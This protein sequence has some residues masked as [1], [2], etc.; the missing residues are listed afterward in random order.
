[1]STALADFS[2][3]PASK[4]QSKARIALAGPSG[5]GKTYTA[6]TIAT[7]FGGP[8]AVIDTERGSASKYAGIFQFDRLNMTRYDPR[9]LPKALASASAAGYPVVIID[10]LSKFWGGEGGML[11]QVDNAAKRSYGGNSFG[12]WKE[13]RPMETAMIEAILSYPGHVIVTMRTKTAYEIIEDDRGRKR[14]EKIGLKPEQRDGIEYEFDIVGDMDLENTLTVSKSRCPALSGE[15]IARPGE[16]FARA[17]LD[18][19]SDGE[20]ALSAADYREQAM[21]PGAA[22]EALKDLYLKVKAAGLLGAAVTDSS[23]DAMSLGQLI[24]S[25]GKQAEARETFG[26]QAAEAVPPAGAGQAEPPA[27]EPQDWPPAA[28]EAHDVP[29]AAWIDGILERAAAV[30]EATYKA[31]WAEVAAG[32]KA[33]E[34]TPDER[35]Y[36]E[37]LI[38][39]R[40]QDIRASAS[41]ADLDPEDPWYDKVQ[42]IASAEDAAAAMADVR[43]TTSLSKFRQDAII[44]AIAAREASLTGAAA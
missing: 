40:M 33:G 16:E 24:I 13:A 9:D 25:L 27:A 2:F 12:G 20:P 1:M 15:V 10:S 36:A 23:G 21:T 41:A 7:A 32:Q 3:E 14:P 28:G 31:L 37:N 17:V 11:Q 30:T 22:Y 4:A 5:S 44:A 8:V 38:T 34:C 35:K 39:A 19:L 29:P 18:W 26:A 42:S 43:N 6:L